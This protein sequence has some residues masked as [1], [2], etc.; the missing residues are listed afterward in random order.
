MPSDLPKPTHPDHITQTLTFNKASERARIDRVSSTPYHRG[1]Y[2]HL[3]TLQE[4]RLQCQVRNFISAIGLDKFFFLHLPSFT[5]LTHEFFTTFYFDRPAM[6]NLHTPDIIGFRLLGQRF[7]LSLQEFGTAMGCECLDSTW[8]FSAEFNPST[9][10]L[11]LCDNPPDSYSPTRSKDLYLKNSSLKYLHKFLAYTFS[12]RKDAPNILT[13][14][15]L[16]ILWCMH[17]HQKIHLGYCLHRRV[18]S[19]P[20]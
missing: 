4:L 9:A 2:I 15:E 6:H 11:E 20:E 19:R 14:T 3:G 18:R 10:Y 16:Y 8:D 1:K 12:G 7:R 5:E 17:T 13:R